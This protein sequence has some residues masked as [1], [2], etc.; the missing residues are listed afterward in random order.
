MGVRVWTLQRQAGAH[1]A[2]LSRMMREEAARTTV[3]PRGPRR[4]VAAAVARLRVRTRWLAARHGPR[5]PTGPRYARHRLWQLF[6]WAEAVRL[7]DEL[8]R[9]GLRHLHVHFS[10][11]SADIARLVVEIGRAVDGPGAGWR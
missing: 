1:E 2:L 4:S 5:R 7:H 3:L 8:D 9:R 11:N 10:N 6:Y